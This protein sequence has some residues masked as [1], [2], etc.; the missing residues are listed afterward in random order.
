MMDFDMFVYVSLNAVHF[1]YASDAKWRLTPVNVMLFSFISFFGVFHLH[2]LSLVCFCW[3]LWVSSPGYPTCLRLKGFV[4]V[5]F[6]VW[7]LSE[8]LP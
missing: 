2:V 8:L 3:L 1:M 7:L 4:I 6:A 5:V